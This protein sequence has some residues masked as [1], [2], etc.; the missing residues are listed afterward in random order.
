MEELY[1]ERQLLEDYFTFLRIPSISADPAHADDV[2]AACSFVEGYLKDSDLD[3]EVWETPDY[4]VVFGSYLEAGPGKP[5]LLI[6]GHYDVQPVDPLDEWITP[7][8]EPT[9]R[10]GQVYARGAQD[11]KGQIL[12]TM[13]A[14]RA[15][16]KRDGK[17]PI[18]LKIVVEG[19]EETKSLGFAQILQARAQDL[20]ADYLLAPDFDIPSIDQP[21]VTCGLRGMIALTVEL[22]S[23]KIDLHS[24][25]H[26]GVVYNPNHALVEMLAKLRDAEG[27][28]TVRGFYDDVEE[29]NDHEKQLLSLEFDE[30][31]YKRD[32]GAQMTGGE[33][34][35]TPGQSN[36]V[37]PTLELNGIS[38]GYAGPGIKTVIPARAEAKISC[39][40]VPGQD[41]EKIIRAIKQQLEETLPEGVEMKITEYGGDRA[42]K[43]APDFPFVRALSQAYKEV[44][45]KEC[46]L[47]LSGGS[48]P[49]SAKLSDACGAPPVFMG[50]GL[51]DDDIHAPNEHF[52]IDRLKLGFLTVARLLEILR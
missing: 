42:V 24:G 26:G 49:I 17:L 34:G 18:N 50:I 36:R 30:E 16:M 43:T 47:T 52:G 9:V 28:V 11:N 37:R 4:P 48:V 8:F 1:D 5:T 35:Y 22:W 3:V 44:F 10:D 38:G 41:P 21:A 14:I 32:F 29:L 23:S 33:K 20:Q 51:I 45:G 46:K 13:Y 27:R 12:Y 7:P 40:L 6:Y 2:R 19:Q 25:G 39:R 15:L 31:K